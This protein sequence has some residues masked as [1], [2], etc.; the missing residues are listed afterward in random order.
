MMRHRRAGFSL[1]EVLLSTS[2]LLGSSVVLIEL[3]TIGRKQA[4]TAYDLNQAQLI[5]QAKLD[6]IVAGIT[7]VKAVEDEEIEE[8]PGWFYSIESQP[9]RS[10]NLAAVKV[11]VYQEAEDQKRPVRFSLV[12]WVPESLVSSSSSSSDARSTTSSGTTAGGGS[13]REDQP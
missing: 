12:R 6:E 3:A 8:H 13:R 9:V 5:C 7:M 1:M 10:H 11:S 2:I 4:S